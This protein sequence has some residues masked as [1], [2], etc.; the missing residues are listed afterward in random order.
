MQVSVYVYTY[1]L[2]NNASKSS[3]KS[4]LTQFTTTSK[5]NGNQ[6]HHLRSYTVNKTMPQQTQ[7]WCKKL[8]DKKQNAL[9]EVP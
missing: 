8:D 1:I 3:K 4:L 2:D 7:R 9:R 5:I 6:I